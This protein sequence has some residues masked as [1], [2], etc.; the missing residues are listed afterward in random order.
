MND[1]FQIRISGVNVMGLIE[2]EGTFKPVLIFHDGK[3]EN[4]INDKNNFGSDKKT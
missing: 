4:Q 3:K 1:V 2:E